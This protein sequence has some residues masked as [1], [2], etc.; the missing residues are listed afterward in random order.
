MCGTARSAQRTLRNGKPMGRRFYTPEDRR[1]VALLGV[2]VVGLAAI[3]V[4]QVVDMR[5]A[6]GLGARAIGWLGS[7]RS[8]HAQPS[9]VRIAGGQQFLWA[10]GPPDAQREDSE[11]FDLTGS[12]LP[13]DRFEHG[14]GRD[15]IRSIDQPVLVKADDVRLR[16]MYTARPDGDISGLQVIGYEHN[17]VARAYPLALLNHHEL[18]NDTVGGKPV[19]V[20]W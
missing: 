14:I 12:P 10:K 13:L 3:I 17:G 18:V 2:V 8:A 6:G 15:T 19:T 20:G 7:D 9:K 16:E 11:W 5:V 4:G 1:T